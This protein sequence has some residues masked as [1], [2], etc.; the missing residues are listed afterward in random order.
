[1]DKTLLSNYARLVVKTGVN[2]QA[3]QLLV[4]N[5][6]LECADFARLI[7][8]EA[9]D[10]GAAD[11]SIQWKDELFS[12]LRYDK[13]PDA[14]FDQ[15]PAYLQSFYQEQAKKGAAFVSIAANDPELLKGVVPDKIIR[16]Q[17]A[18][19]T[20][21]ADYR[22]KLMANYNAWCVVSVPTVAWAK[23]VF[24]DLTAEAAVEALGAAIA[25]AVRIDQADPVAAWEAHK[26]H[27]HERMTWLNDRQFRRVRI[28]TGLGT[29][30]SIGLP[31]A[32]LWL[33][34]AE[35]TKGGVPFVANMPTEEI[36]TLPD[37]MAVDGKVV[38]SRP[39][40]YNGNLIDGF[41]LE[42]KAGRCVASQAKEGE[43]ILRQLLATDP[44]AAHL[45]EVAL[46]PHSSPISMMGML[47]FNTLFDEN[48]SA[49][50]AFGKAYPVCLAGS[51]GMDKS[52]LLAAG[53]NDSLVHEDFMI[54]TA[55]MLVTGETKTGE[56]VTI[57]QNGE[58]VL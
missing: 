55:D 12:R 1:M 39:L 45:G 31:A 53:V 30:V 22:E 19:N 26:H 54:G 58:F 57:M 9:Y 49:H 50:L 37:R 16:A 43:A 3:G 28:Q 25:R 13:A 42:F 11:V 2:L 40:V 29:D 34:G 4:V 56:T 35:K 17:K 33:G 20:A 21:L 8:S 47:F 23:K 15:Y 32:H 52:A 41:S 36:F 46:V 6:P 27:L 24:P 5:A 7:A 51:E 10:A 48:A 14:V 44:G 18:A 38:A